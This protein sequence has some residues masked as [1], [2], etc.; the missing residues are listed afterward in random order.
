M[1]R[2]LQRAVNMKIKT[3]HTD[4]AREY[5]AAHDAHDKR[6]DLPEALGLY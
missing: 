3:E 4:A 6:H 1:N 5:A 2:F